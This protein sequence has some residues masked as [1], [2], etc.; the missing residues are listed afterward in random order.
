MSAR[1]ESQG[2][3][4]DDSLTTVLP[5]SLC[6]VNVPTTVP[7]FST[8]FPSLAFP[9]FRSNPLEFFASAIF[10]PFRAPTGNSFYGREREQAETRSRTTAGPK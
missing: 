4:P 3:R 1:T 2:D 10:L 6:T 8:L 7:P 9:G 5:R